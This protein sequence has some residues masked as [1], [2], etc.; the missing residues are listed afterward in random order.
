VGATRQPD[1]EFGELA[2]PAV[3]ADCAAM[4]LREMS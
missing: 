2:D 1:G 4:L 3:D